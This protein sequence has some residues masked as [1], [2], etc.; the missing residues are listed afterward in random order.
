MRKTKLY[1]IIWG[2]LFLFTY[3]V[4]ANAEIR[5]KSK[6]NIIPYPQNWEFGEGDFSLNEATAICI[7]DTRALS[8]AKFYSK[9]MYRST[10]FS[11]PVVKTYAKNTIHLS[12]ETIADLKPEGYELEVNP[13][14]IKIKASTPQGLFYGMASLMQLLPPEIESKTR[15]PNTTW[16]IPAIHIKDNP[17]FAYRG[18]MID[19]VRHFIPLEGLKKQIDLLAMYKMNR[20]HLHLTDYQG[21]RIEIKK[22]PK[23]TEVGGTRIDENG[24]AYSGYYTQDDIRELIKY[25]AERYITII[26]EIDVPAHSLAAIAAYPELSCTGKQYSVMSRWG[27]FPVVLCPGKEVMFEM[28]DNIFAE[29]SPLFTSEYFHIGGDEC[30]KE[31]WKKC[32]YCQRRIH[33]EHLYSDQKHTAEEKLQSYAISRCAKILKKY[34]KKM[35]GWD[36]ILDGGIAPNATVM[37]WRGES[38]AIASAI[39]KH[40]VIMTPVDGA[41]YLD[42]YQGDGL[43]EP[44]AWGGYAPIEKTYAY[45]PIPDKL[46][47]I[48][49]KKYVIG[50]QANAWAECM[51]TQSQAEYQ[52]YPRVLAVAEVGWTNM[53]NKNFVDFSRRLNDASIRMD[54]HQINYHIPL[55]EQPGGSVNQIA[56]LDSVEV[57]FQTSRPIKMIYTLDKTVPNAFSA[58][59]IHPLKFTKS[60]EI[61]IRSILPS[62]KMSMVRTIKVE[63]Q[64]WKEALKEAPKAKGLRLKIADK[65]C[66]LIEDLKRIK[67]W[68]DSLI[69]TINVISTLRPNFY[70]DVAYYAAIAEGAIYIKEDGIYYFQSDNSRVDVGEVVVVDNDGKP[71]VNSKYGR[72]LALRKGWHKLRVMQISNFIGGWNSQHRNNGSISLRKA[73]EKEWKQV[74]AD[75]LGHYR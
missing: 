22:Y 35:I 64:T 62:N 42:Y 10:G 50:V 4:T 37:S 9:K 7:S 70:T 28:L 31:V 54:M 13:N 46:L 56:F 58:E 67:Q 3:P 12:L 18:L 68:K 19:V 21:W 1:S 75:Q 26:P 14:V 30:P 36:E 15:V 71:Q 55:P 25:A 63:K 6:I 61:N 59:Y 73:G 66:M 38:G 51:Y 40:D 69:T 5:D 41:M 65:K 24:K 29:L 8:V 32:E 49:K 33:D 74:T 72:A 27:R 20:V 34:G 52:I 48:G 60:G 57:E 39:M 53:E 43:A 44:F 16:T 23:L 2:I 45:N 11:L 47:T 17:R